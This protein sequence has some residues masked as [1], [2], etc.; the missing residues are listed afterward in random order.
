MGMAH[1]ELLKIFLSRSEAPD[2]IILYWKT[3]CG[4]N[5]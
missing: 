3:Y 5:S 2:S 4:L 1:G